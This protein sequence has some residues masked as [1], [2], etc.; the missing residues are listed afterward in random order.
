MPARLGMLPLIAQLRALCAVGEADLI[1]GAT[2]YWSDELLQAELDATRRTLYGAP[3]LA[4]PQFID[5]AYRYY[6]YA[7]PTALGVWVE[8]AAP[9]S[10]FA[11]RSAAGVALTSGFTVN[12][13]ARRVVFAQ[14][15]AGASYTLDA[16]FYDLY[17]AAASIW[18]QKAAFAAARLDW[19][20][21]H[22][23]KASQ[24]Y[25]HCAAQA[26]RFRQ[27]SGVRT[28]TFQRTDEVRE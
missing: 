28:A 14:D 2:T 8:Q 23:L 1:V 25:E 26:E 9:E 16:R 24:E 17:S 7:F 13:R 22:G 10:G 11:V 6:E 18:E 5:G 12:Y 3:L 4:L 21:T 19:A 20:G 15:Q 27:L